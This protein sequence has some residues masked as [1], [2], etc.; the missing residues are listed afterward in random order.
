[1][2]TSEI[3]TSILS[4]IAS[5]GLIKFSQ[6]KVDPYTRAIIGIAVGVGM[7]TNKREF[8]QDLGL[9]A[10]FGS[11]LQFTD[12]KKGGKISINNFNSVIFILS[13]K[14]GISE[15]QPFQIPDFFIDGLTMKGIKGVFKVSNGVYA[16]INSKGVISETVG[17]GKLVN[18][19]HDAGLKNKEWVQSQSDTRW[20]NLYEK[21]I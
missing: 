8:V 10:I 21:S 20:L 16:K 3:S 15:L 9:G 19:L 4:G 7:Q 1:M 2:K 18:K 6:S 14:E 12:I 17:F 13:E 11:A 5:F